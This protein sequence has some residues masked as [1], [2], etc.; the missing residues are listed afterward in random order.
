MIVPSNRRR[1]WWLPAAVATLGVLATLPALGL[2]IYDLSDGTG[3]GPSLVGLFGLRG[4]RLEDAI[5]GVLVT[6]AALVLLTAWAWWGRWRLPWAV[7]L[8]TV[9]GTGLLAVFGVLDES[10]RPLATGSMTAKATLASG[11]AAL[12]VAYGLQ[13]LAALLGL[14]RLAS[15]PTR[16]A[17]SA[18]NSVAAATASPQG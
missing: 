8:L 16:V 1:G 10:A 3:P 14:L 7:L 13:L 9:G 12:V 17:G 11:G 15:P 4:V 18:N 5:G 2:P 6:L